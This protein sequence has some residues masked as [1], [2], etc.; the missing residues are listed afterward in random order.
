MTTLTESINENGTT[1][2]GAKI[3]IKN[4]IYEVVVVTGKSNY[5]NINKKTANPFGYGGKYF[6]DFD[7]ASRN[8]KSAS[9]KVALLELETLVLA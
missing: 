4:T 1:Y 2:Q 5:I 6:N 3:Q 7:H 8:Y 9:M